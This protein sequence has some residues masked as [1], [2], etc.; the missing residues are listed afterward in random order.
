MAEDLAQDGRPVKLPGPG[1]HLPRHHRERRAQDRREGEHHQE[2]P[3]P[4]PVPRGRA[5]RPD[6]ASGP[7]LQG[8]G[9]RAGHGAGPARLHRAPPALP[10]AGPGHPHH[11]RRGRREA[12]HPEERRRHR[13]RGAGRL[14]RAP[15]RRDGRAQQRARRV[16]V[17][18]RAA[19]HQ[20][21][22]RHGRRAHLRPPGHPA[23]RRKLGCHDRRLGPPA[24]RRPSPHLRPH[25][26][27][28]PRREPSGV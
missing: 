28:S 15:V 3:Q 25:R 11:R 18:R 24:L 20:V 22:G 2:P 23:R 14:Q 6:R 19:R 13:P 1:H 4:D 27:R 10:G 7:L 17:L 12:E 21:R 5:F 16:A 8:R 9:A 26:S